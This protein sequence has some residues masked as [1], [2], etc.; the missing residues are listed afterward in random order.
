VAAVLLI[1]PDPQQQQQLKAA[2]SRAGYAPL[3]A[4]DTASGIERL[5]E[6]G[7]D[8]AVVHYTEGVQMD[9]FASGLERLPDPPPFLLVSGAV[10][11]P[12][13]SARY[14][15]AEFVARP[16]GA[17]EFLAVVRRVLASRTSSSEFEEVPTRPNERKPN[18]EP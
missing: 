8:L 4:S 11:A 6:G 1:D 13:M 10:D 5:R 12:A 16:C 9:V 15:A 18:E 2:L 17:E 14:G 3:V 7:I